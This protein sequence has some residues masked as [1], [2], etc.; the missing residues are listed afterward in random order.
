MYDN[1]LKRLLREIFLYNDG[2][3]SD[4][5]EQAAK[6]CSVDYK[7]F[8]KYTDPNSATNIPATRLRVL[9]IYMLT[10]RRD[11]RIAEWL[12]GPS[13][14]ICPAEADELNGEISDEILELDEFEG[15]VIRAIK[16]GDK[17]KAEAAARKL[18][19][20]A[21]RLKAEVHDAQ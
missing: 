13:F 7:T 8:H 19:G 21:N 6:V 2:D 3:G 18:I 11:T 10:E 5:L 20:V 14:S 15:D 12:C 17:R 16:S 9:N 4:T 1:G